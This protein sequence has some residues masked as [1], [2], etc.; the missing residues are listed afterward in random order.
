[1]TMQPFLLA[2]VAI[3]NLYGIVDD[4]EIGS[5]AGDAALNRERPHAAAVRGHEI[6]DLGS[7]FSKS[8]IQRFT[9]PIASENRADGIGDFI[10]EILTI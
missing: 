2:V 8:S 3:L 10:G 1:M 5:K 6:H 4:D 7:I 9:K